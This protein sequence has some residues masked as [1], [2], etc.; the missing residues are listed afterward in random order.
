MEE[1]SSFTSAL[2]IVLTTGRDARGWQVGGEEV[3]DGPW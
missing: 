1:L 3:K 2:S